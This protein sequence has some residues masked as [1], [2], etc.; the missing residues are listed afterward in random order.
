MFVDSDKH[1]FLYSICLFL[2]KKLGFLNIC[3][4]FAC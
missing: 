1:A 3:R 2:V 4:I